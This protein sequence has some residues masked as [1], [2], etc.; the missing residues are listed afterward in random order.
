MRS[1][2]ASLMVYFLGLLSLALVTASLLAYQTSYLTLQDKKT[3]TEALIEKQY[4]E[5][6]KR[7]RDRLDRRLADQA[8][9]IARLVQFHIELPMSREERQGPVFAWLVASTQG[10]TVAGCTTD[11]CLWCSMFPTRRDEGK[12]DGGKPNGNKSELIKVEA[13]KPDYP[14]RRDGRADPFGYLFRKREIKLSEDDLFE[15]MAL[16]GGPAE[17]FQ[18]DAV[19]LGS[20]Q[21]DKLGKR[22]LSFDPT[23]IKPLHPEYDI[24]ELTPDNLHLRRVVL[25]IPTGMG[26]TGPAGPPR[27][28]GRQGPGAPD[29]AVSLDFTHSRPLYI[30]C[31]TP[32]TSLEHRLQ[33]LDDT[34]RAELDKVEEDATESRRS[35]RNRLIGMSLATFAIIAFGTWYL[36]RLGLSPLQRLSVAVSKVSAKDFRLQFDDTRLP[37]ELQPIRDRLVDTLEQLK[38]A[39]DREKQ[40]TADIS[41]ELRTPLAALLTTMELALRKTR[42]PDEYREMLQDCLLSGQ[43][44][45]HVVERLLALARLDAGSDHLRPKQVDVSQL[46]DQCVAMVRPLAEAKGLNLRVHHAAAVEATVDPAK[47]REMMIN[48][49]H[50]AIQYNRPNGSVTLSVARSDAYLDVS[51][52]DTGIGILAEK[53]AQIFERFYRADP[54]RGMDGAHAGLGLAIVK[55]YVDLMGGTLEVDSEVEQGS[56][57]RI[58]LPLPA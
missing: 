42:T 14:P 7:E 26:P 10:Q 31:A 27:G 20:F 56:T 47:L 29:R 46:A 33:E 24:V 3:A 34:R 21:S 40:A 28:P 5:S 57:F 49:L 9:A 35:L 15:K 50:N 44:M 11:I 25:N 51:V 43:H 23:M 53:R 32:T 54:S 12:P 22:S 8:E 19:Q 2:R 52:S 16:V 18:I 30:Q 1:I 55:G 36:V 41:H 45:S 39:F 17:Y 4:T 38:R 37:S 58:R 6:C 48:L 13:G